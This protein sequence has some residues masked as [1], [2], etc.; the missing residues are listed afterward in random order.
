MK[1]QIHFLWL[2]LIRRIVITFAFMGKAACRACVFIHALG[3]VEMKLL[4]K[5]SKSHSCYRT[6]G[7]VPDGVIC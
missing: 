3:T 2:S 4:G 5:R 6:I 7:K 1:T